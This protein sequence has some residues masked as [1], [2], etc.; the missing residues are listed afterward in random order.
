M[1]PVAI[2]RLRPGD[3]ASDGDFAARIRMAGTGAIS[4]PAT[5]PR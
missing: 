5:P 3:E 1:R 2:L 4:R